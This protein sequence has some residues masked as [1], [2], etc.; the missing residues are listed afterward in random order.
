M[1]APPPEAT[2]RA[3][4]DWILRCA[5]RLG[6]VVPETP[7]ANLEPLRNL[8]SGATVVGLGRSTHGT[9]ELAVLARRVVHWLVENL[10]FRTLAVEEDWSTG[11]EIDTWLRTGRGDLRDVLDNALPHYQTGEFFQLL[12]ELRAHNE[13]DPAD[14]VRFAGLDVSGVRALAYDAV[15]D[16]VRRSAPE[17]LAELEDHYSLLRPTG[18]IA[19]H[20]AWLQ[21]RSD[22]PLL[23]EQARRAHELVERLPADTDKALA[24]RH[25]NAVVAFYQAYTGDRM[26]TVEP[27]LADNLIWWHQRTGHNIVYWGGFPHTAVGPTRQVQFPGVDPDARENAGSRLRRHFGASYRSIGLTWHH[28]SVGPAPFPVTVPPPTPS[29]ADALLGAPELTSYLLDVHRDVPETVQT[30]LHAPTTLRL[31]GPRYAPEV[32]HNSH[33]TGGSLADWFDVLLHT[34]QVTPAHP[35]PPRADSA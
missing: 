27:L 1:D 6:T 12:V 29:F 17:L 35:L 9:H 15:T 8:L 3:V 32:D 21:D 33:M 13:Q 31:V 34:Q 10:G 25:A 24:L 16:Y 5:H 7:S 20:I 28:G 23:I 11:V 2:R 26:A 18:S 4:N 30:W 22:K 14:P 19:A